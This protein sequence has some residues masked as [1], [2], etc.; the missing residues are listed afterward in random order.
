M[1]YLTIDKKFL[2]VMKELAV[3]N[4]VVPSRK[5]DAEQKMQV[6]TLLGFF[7]LL[8]QYGI[9]SNIELDKELTTTIGLKDGESKDKE[10]E[11]KKLKGKSKSKKRKKRTRPNRV[12]FS[13]YTRSRR[14][15]H[16][17]S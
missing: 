7:N 5:L 3:E 9:T 16:R 6:W 15:V 2:S 13:E 8:K 14:R 11:G 1:T 4:P 10:K 12:S 17:S